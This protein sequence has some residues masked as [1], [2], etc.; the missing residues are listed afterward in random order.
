[1]Q[2]FRFRNRWVLLAQQ[3]R[4]EDVADFRD[5]FWSLVRGYIGA[6]KYEHAQ[7]L[8]NA[9]E[10]F[11]KGPEYLIEKVAKNALALPPPVAQGDGGAGSHLREFLLKLRLKMVL[12][13]V[14]SRLRSGLSSNYA[15]ARKRLTTIPYWS[16]FAD[17]QPAADPV[18]RTPD[19]GLEIVSLQTQLNISRFEIEQLHRNLH[20][21]RQDIT[22]TLARNHL[23]HS[24]QILA[25]LERA[26]L[27]AL[28]LLHKRHA[29]RRAF[30]VGNGPSL[31][32]ADLDRLHGEITFA[33]NKIYLAFEDTTWRPDFY[34][35][36]DS[37]VLQNNRDRITA[38]QGTTKIFPANMRDFGHH[39]ADTIF[40]PFHAPKS[41]DDPLSDPEFPEFSTDLR[42][43]IGWGSTI[44]YSQIQ[45]ALFMGC[46]DIYLIGIDHDYHLPS[47]KRGRFYISEDEKN[48]FH[49][50]YREVGEKWHQPNLDVLEI[51]YARARDRCADQGVRVLNASRKTRLQVFDLIDFDTLF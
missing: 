31:K 42:H 24:P 12:R 10:D 7:L 51:S 1:M 23:L 34:S 49:P 40:V 6:R 9:M 48:H 37:L 18:L 33:S 21:S 43:G 50:E 36:E 19:M 16:Q 4:L 5:Q 17:N 3:G 38:L 20:Q 41:F 32:I 8:L 28:S 47:V 26:N 2:Y 22:E 15:A 39:S 27:V 35:V 25:D 46:R 44:V 14:E 30:I 45:M 11:L 29:G 13:R